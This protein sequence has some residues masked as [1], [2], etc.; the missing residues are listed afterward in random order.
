MIL[1]A[2]PQLHRDPSRVVTRPGVELG[3]NTRVEGNATYQQRNSTSSAVAQPVSDDESMM[4]SSD[5]VVF[6]NVPDDDH[7]ESPKD[8]LTLGS[9]LPSGARPRTPMQAIEIHKKNEEK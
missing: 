9:P 5:S 8:Y 6:I 1:R 4:S 3:Q 2:E 7:I